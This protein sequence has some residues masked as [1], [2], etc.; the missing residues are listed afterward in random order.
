MGSETPSTEADA[1]LFVYRFPTILQGAA[2]NINFSERTASAALITESFTDAGPCGGS[3]SYTLSTESTTGDFSG[4]FV[5]TQYCDGGIV[6]SGPV[7]VDGSISLLT[8]E[9]EVIH[10]NFNNVNSGDI[11]LS[12]DVRT[13][14]TGTPVTITM[15]FLVR[16]NVT[17]KVFWVNDYLLTITEISDS[18]I[19]VDITGTYYNPEFGYITFYTL[20]PLVIDD[21]SPWPKDGVIIYEGEDNTSAQLTVLDQLSYRVVADTDGDGS[22]DNYDSGDLLWANL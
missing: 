2:A 9:I 10:F 15:D 3:V 1:A 17:G 16:D 6:I 8:S 18:E 14:Q 4:S 22:R 19:E 11:T 13:D 12:G 5:F 21:L 7:A 20:D